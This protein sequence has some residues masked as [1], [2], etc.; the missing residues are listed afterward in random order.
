MSSYVYMKMLES[1]PKRYDRGIAMLSFGVLDRV[2]ASLVGPAVGR[3]DT[4]LDIG[5]GTGRIALLAAGAGAAVTGIDVSPSML[6]VARNK[7]TAAGLSRKVELIEMGVSGMETLRAGGFSVVCASLLF[8]ELSTDEQ[9]FALSHAWRL[10]K[11]GGRLLLIDEVRPRRT[12]SRALYSLIRAPLVIVTFLLTQTTTRPTQALAERV[13]EA[14]FTVTFTRRY[15]FG[16]LLAL[17]AAK[18]TVMED[19]K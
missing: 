15:A 2:A 13:A 8:S 4:V 17:A 19:R 14:G 6:A 11:P 3:P 1:Q 18:E 5:C 12:L 10:L 9:S 7:V 16:S